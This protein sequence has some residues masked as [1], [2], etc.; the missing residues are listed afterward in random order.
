M[1]FVRSFAISFFLLG[2]IELPALAGN[3][4]GYYPNYWERPKPTPIISLSLD[5]QEVLNSEFRI[6][7]REGRQEDMMRFL[8][9]KAG[10]NSH[11]DEGA[12][13]LMY[14][15]LNCFPGIVK[16][17][18]SHGAD[19]NVEDMQ[20]ATALIDAAQ[21]SCAPVIRLLVRSPGI[22]IQ[23]QDKAGNSAIDYARNNASLD[24]DGP[25]LEAV[26]LLSSVRSRNARD[27]GK[28]RA[29][30]ALKPRVESLAAPDR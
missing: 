1:G 17:L 20:G 14:A 5:P 2:V 9:Q 13:A 15:S 25:P 18:L 22:H 3:Y 16:N 8:E 29:K 26:R 19:V 28:A 11:S 10:I 27:K 12:T 6:A 7:A 23:H 24:V 30:L 21:D 4:S